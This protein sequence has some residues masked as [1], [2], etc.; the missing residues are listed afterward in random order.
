MSFKLTP[1]RLAEL[2]KAAVDGILTAYE[3]QKL[4]DHIATH[5]V[6]LG[7]LQGKC[8]EVTAQKYKV[9]MLHEPV[10]YAYWD[11]SAD[12]RRTVIVCRCCQDWDHDD[13]DVI[14]HPCSTIEALDGVRR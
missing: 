8:N 12:E 7:D 14:T 11:E 2:R 6:E 9:R 1:Q 13:A 4:L 10:E 5:D 3:S